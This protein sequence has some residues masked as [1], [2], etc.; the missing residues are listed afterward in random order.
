MSIK[1]EQKIIKKNTIFTMIINGFLAAGKMIAG[2]LGNSSVLISDAINS[3]G[4]MVTNVVVYVSAI[5]SRK[6]KDSNHPY[7]HEKIDSIISIFL[8]VALIL[9]AFTVGKSALVNLYNYFIN[10]I[11]ILAPKWYA[12]IVAALTIVIKELLFR[13]TKKDAEKSKSSALLAQAWDH[14]ADTIGSFGAVIGITG[15]M[16]GFGFLDPIASFVIALIILKL[17]YKIISSGVSQVVDKSADPIVVERIKE[18]IFAFEDIRS[19]DDIKTR[20]FGMKLYV[21]L[22]IGLDYT[23]SLEAA[24]EIAERLHDKIENTIPEVLHCMIHI[25]PYHPDKK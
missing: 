6:E 18:V 2:I 7:G 19:L 9:T 3:I 16:L 8:G 14:R 21:D 5:F 13:K 4:D 25:N 1:E 12:L 17:A 20:M 15:A 24:H 10:D 11:D 22:E 23:L